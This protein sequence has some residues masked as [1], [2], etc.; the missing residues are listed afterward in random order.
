MDFF[1]VKTGMYF[2]DCPPPPSWIYLVPT[3]KGI[4]PCQDII[5]QNPTPVVAENEIF[6]KR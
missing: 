3:T 5:F 6:L 2:K 4:F 1:G